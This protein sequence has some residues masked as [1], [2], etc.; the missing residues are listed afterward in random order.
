MLS[1]DKDF[2]IL[3]FNRNDFIYGK[4]SF[5]YPNISLDSNYY[6]FYLTSYKGNPQTIK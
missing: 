5:L 6:K 1:R 3:K 4:S 2:L